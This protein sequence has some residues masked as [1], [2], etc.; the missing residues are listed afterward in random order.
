MPERR[1][2]RSSLRRRALLSN[3]RRQRPAGPDFE[4]HARQVPSAVPARRLKTARAAE[5]AASSS[6]ATIASAAEIHVPVTFETNGTTGA[7]RS[8]RSTSARKASRAGS[9]I[10]EWKACEVSS[11]RAVTPARA[12]AVSHAAIASN[13]PDTTQSAGP[14]DCGQRQTVRQQRH[15]LSLRQRHGQHRA[16]PAIACISRPR[17]ATSASA[18]WSENT[19]A[20]HAA[21]YSPMLWPM[22]A[23]GRTPQRIHNCASAYSIT[24]NAGCANRVSVRAEPPRASFAAFLAAEHQRRA[25]RLRDAR[26]AR[27]SRHRRRPG[28]T[29]R[30]RR[31]RGPCRRTA[32]P[33]R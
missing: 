1:R 8:T 21:T 20:R 9:I 4:E 7:R 31:A 16:R 17:A 12:S 29:A 27:R 11:R 32:R 2:D 26:S 25:G 10:A 22:N 28:T 23:D 6:P 13:G 3:E 15:H 33:A 5:D 30:S 18:S 19:P 24:N 14:F